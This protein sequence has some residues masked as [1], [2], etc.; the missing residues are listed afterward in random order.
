MT[1]AQIAALIAALMAPCPQCR[2]DADP[3]EFYDASQKYSVDADIL[4]HW[5]FFE[6][7]LSSKAIGKL[8]E[9]G[10]FQVHGAHRK[11]CEDAGLD[12]LGVGC[13]AYLI[14]TDRY[15]CGSL[16]RGLNRYAS[17]SCNGTPRSIRLVKYRLRQINKW[18]KK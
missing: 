10:L 7:S 15:E 14:A 13:G 16:E 17:G 3:Q 2:I 12:P 18:S 6:S 11:A 1:V 4:V 9:V 8:G 5:A